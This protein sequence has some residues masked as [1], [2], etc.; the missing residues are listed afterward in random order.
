MS[1]SD[2]KI[3][4]VW[5]KATAVPSYN[6]DM[7]RKDQ[8]GAWIKRD[9]YG[10]RKH[11]LGWEVDHITPVSKG[12]GDELSNLAPLHWKNNEAKGDGALQCVVTSRGNKNVG[13]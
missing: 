4:Q 8:C 12:G 10:N 6:K 5:N 13:L 3:Q 2:E 11:A 9:E 1:F 7:Y